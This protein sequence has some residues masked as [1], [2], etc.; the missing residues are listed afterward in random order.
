VFERFVHRGIHHTDVAD[1]RVGNESLRP[2]ENPFAV[3]FDRRGR[4]GRGVRTGARLRQSHAPDPFA[5]G[6]LRNVFFQLFG[7]TVFEDRVRAQV[8]VGAQGEQVALIDAGVPQSL[9][10][11][12]AGLHAGARSAQ[13]LRKRKAQDAHLS[14]LPPHLHGELAFEIRLLDQRHNFFF[15][16]L[17]DR[18]F[19]HQLFFR[20]A[21]FHECLLIMPYFPLTILERIC[22]LICSLISL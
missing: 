1:R 18:I 17:I 6:Q 19:E 7:R 20:K 2:V 13:F 9:A 14:Q 12:A 5:A 15:C 3:F 10:G 11:Q 8:G 4:D 21:E 16:E 22:S